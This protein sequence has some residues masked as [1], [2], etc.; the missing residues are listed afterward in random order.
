MRALMSIFAG[1]TMVVA[2][3]VDGAAAAAAPASNNDRRIAA[4]LAEIIAMEARV[5][6]LAARLA[7]GAAGWCPHTMPT[8]GW[9][10]GDRRLYSDR[11]WPQARAAYAVADT[12]ALFIAALDPEGAA[13]HAG[14][15]VGDSITGIDGMAA[16][17]IDDSPHGRMAWAQAMLADLPAATPL[18]V[19][20]ARLPRPVRLAPAPG[21]SSEFR[22]E[23]DDA[24]KAQADGTVVYIP[25]GMVRFAANDE[26]LATVI[27]HEL[28]HNILRHRARLDAA[29]I[30]RGLGQQFGRSAR[31]TRL[32]EIEAD[33]LSVWLLADAGFAP[34]TAARFW[35][36]YGKR[37]GGGIFAAP[38][39]PKWR[40]RV[41]IVA[42][43]EAAMQR[44]RAANPVTAP[45][46][47]AN[48]TPLE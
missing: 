3:P 10:L 27:A 12:D 37:R 22:V 46:L 43:E 32:T 34:G 19:H 8:P 25:G 7:R 48:P 41:R 11:V 15:R 9:L 26:E 30:D 20:I 24:V 40:E 36:S 23:A 18:E 16:T 5:A 4:A 45:P 38:T 29:G 21:C 47:V 44:L 13:A 17:A 6:P 14:L 2:S 1:L 35:Q 31:L 42:E 33:R 28:A 39:H